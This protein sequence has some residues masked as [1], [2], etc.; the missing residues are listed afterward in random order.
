MFPLPLLTATSPWPPDTATMSF[1]ASR[2]MV[3]VIESLTAVP[4]RSTSM[5]QF[6]SPS[7]F[8][9]VVSG[10]SRMYVA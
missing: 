2:S 6:D 7:A 10:R 1:E 5:A 3:C 9:S 8:R 4:L